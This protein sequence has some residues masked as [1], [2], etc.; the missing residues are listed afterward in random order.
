MHRRTLRT[1]ARAF[2]PHHSLHLPC[3]KL[4]TN[5]RH[6]FIIAKL[7]D[8][9]RQAKFGPPRKPQQFLTPQPD[10][11]RDFKKGRSSLV[12]LASRADSDDRLSRRV[13]Y[14]LL[15]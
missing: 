14:R 1:A 6:A 13:R 2:V 8:L 5:A 7:A 10:A 11:E 4:T 15:V 9:A 3:T 12:D